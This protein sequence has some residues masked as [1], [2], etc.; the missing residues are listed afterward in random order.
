MHSDNEMKLIEKLFS[1]VTKITRKS[2][3]EY[4]LLIEGIH[5][6][7]P[8]EAW[9]PL[10]AIKELVS[11]SNFNVAELCDYPKMAES[12]DWSAIRDSSETAIWNIFETF[13]EK[14]ERGEVP[15]WKHL[16]NIY[17]VVQHISKRILPANKIVHDISNAL[18]EESRTGIMMGCASKGYFVSFHK[19]HHGDLEQSFYSTKLEEVIH[20]FISSIFKAEIDNAIHILKVGDWFK[21]VNNFPDPTKG[22]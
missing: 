22:L 1:S 16:Y 6:T 12:G 10:T 19:D 7:G 21:N 20:F 17:R 5:Y 3:R 13:Y 14:P 9:L 8:Y 18:I 2:D 15:E 4:D 11:W